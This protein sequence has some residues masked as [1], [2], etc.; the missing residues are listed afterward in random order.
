MKGVCPLRKKQACLVIA[1]VVAFTLAFPAS[2]ASALPEGYPEA[3][4]AEAL[5]EEA[6]A[7]LP[8]KPDEPEA[9][10]AAGEIT[11]N[12]MAAVEEAIVEANDFAD[13][14]HMEETAEEADDEYALEEAEADERHNDEAAA[15]EGSVNDD[16]D[17]AGENY[18]AVAFAENEPV[19]EKLY[20]DYCLNHCEAFNE[21]CSYCFYLSEGMVYYGAIPEHLL[22]RSSE[23]H[24]YRYNVFKAYFGEEVT[25]RYLGDFENNSSVGIATFCYDTPGF[26]VE[27][28]Y[29]WHVKN[30]SAVRSECGTGAV[31][32]HVFNETT[33]EPASMND[34]VFIGICPESEIRFF[35]SRCIY[36]FV[37]SLQGE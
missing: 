5:V 4:P 11:D 28:L 22:A 2:L 15:A 6:A 25:R 26:A 27:R 32:Y 29:G 37:K 20:I 34:S 18:K 16:A 10:A 1:L 33:P 30:D 23:R 9:E 35:I 31:E 13:Y 19:G 36:D 14:I 12:E 17:F 24:R 7:E 8:E 21:D 3:E